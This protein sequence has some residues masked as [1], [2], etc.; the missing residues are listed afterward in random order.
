MSFLNH[1]C[2]EPN[3]HIYQVNISRAFP[4]LGCVPVKQKWS[5]KENFVAV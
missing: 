1:L 2:L 5:E 4:F 3:G